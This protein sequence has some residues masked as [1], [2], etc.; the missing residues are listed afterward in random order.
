VARSTPGAPARLRD[1]AGQVGRGWRVPEWRDDGEAEEGAP[2]VAGGGDDIL[3]IGRGEGVRGLQEIAGIGSSGRSSP[4]SGGQR[5]CSA[6]IR[7]RGGAPV[8]GGG[9]PPREAV[10]RV[11][12]SRGEVGEE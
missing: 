12:R 10:G 6:R 8:V 2:V 3:Q 7:A 4:G 11:G 1:D 5:R 9:G